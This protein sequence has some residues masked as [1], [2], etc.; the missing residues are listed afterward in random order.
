VLA[1]PY[2]VGSVRQLYD[3]EAAQRSSVVQDLQQS[4]QQ[5]RK[6]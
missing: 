2:N 6:S 4:E 1:N 3:F 5:T